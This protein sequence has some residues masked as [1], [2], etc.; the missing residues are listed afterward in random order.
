MNRFL[1]SELIS[2]KSGRDLIQIDINNVENL[3]PIPKLEIGEPTK[4]FLQMMS[5]DQVLG[6]KKEIQ[7]FQKPVAQYLQ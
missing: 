3:K 5:G 2:G 6:L 4:P 1:E 7:R